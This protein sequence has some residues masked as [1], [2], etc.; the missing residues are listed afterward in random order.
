MTDPLRNIKGLLFDLDGVLYIGERPIDGA[1]EAV[2]QLKQRG[3]P[4]R[5]TTNTTVR[6]LESLYRKLVGLGLPVERDEVFGVIRAALSYL[7]ARGKP[8]CHFL[9]TEGPLADFAEFP[10]DSDNPEIV[11]MG[12]LGKSWNWEM[13]NDVFRMLVA[14][15]ELVALH[16]GRYWQTEN[17]L[18]IDIGAFVAGLEYATGK[19]ATVIG[20][21][22]QEFF[23]LA[24]EDMGLPASEVAM[25]G[26]D[27]NSDIGGAQQ[28]GMRGILVR[29]GKYREELVRASEV[30]PDLVIDS[31]ANL[32]AL[33]PGPA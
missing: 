22:S 33:L 32:P 13:V 31:I 8:T 1:V 21:P 29:T 20:K 19:T 9:L 14:G 5:F 4:C 7:R 16:K 18:R 25:I 28:A 15:A 12:D 10:Q 27:I 24:L 2:R 6:S 26:D 3:I 11:L 17:G 23:R 30:T